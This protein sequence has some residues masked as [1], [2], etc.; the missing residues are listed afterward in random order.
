MSSLSP[1]TP[2]S[3]AAEESLL[4]ELKFP[5]FLRQLQSRLSSSAGEKSSGQVSPTHSSGMALAHSAVLRY[6]FR[7]AGQYQGVRQTAK[8]F[9]Q[10]QPGEPAGSDPWGPLTPQR[11]SC[12]FQSA[13][14]RLVS[15]RPFVPPAPSLSVQQEEIDEEHKSRLGL[16]ECNMEAA[17]GRSIHPKEKGA[18]RLLQWNLLAD[19]LS[20][21][22]FCVSPV[23]LADQWP[24]GSKIPTTD[25]PP[26]EF[27]AMLKDMLAITHEAK[28]RAAAEK[29]AG[30]TGAEL[31]ERLEAIQDEKLEE[32]ARFKRQYDTHET[33]QNLL[34]CIDWD[35]RLRRMLWLISRASPDIITMQ[36]VDHLNEIQASL[37][38]L[39]YV[40]SVE[41]GEEKAAER[42]KHH[43]LHVLTG[44]EVL[45]RRQAS[46]VAF[47]TKVGS[48]ALLQKLERAMESAGVGATGAVRQLFEAA[49]V[50]PPKSL[51]AGLRSPDFAAAGGY[52]A[53]LEY[54][55]RNGLP[56]LSADS[57]DD[58]GSV[59]FWKADRFEVRSI[60]HCV[61]GEKDGDGGGEGA[62][63]VTLRD[64]V[65]GRDISVC[66]AHL[67]SGN[68]STQEAGRLQQVR[69]PVYS[70]DG[71]SE[72]L[73]SWIG[74]PGERVI[75]AMDANSRPQFPGS[76]TVWRA[77]KSQGWNSVWDKYF[78]EAGE[79]RLERC[80]V[81]VNKMR[82]PGS[83]QAQKI[84]EHA[85]ELIDHV[86][87]RNLRCQGHGLEP[88]TFASQEEA[89]ASLLPTL[90]NPSDHYPVVADLTYA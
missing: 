90:A 33:Q 81:T 72:S 36:E 2:T 60:G 38:P 51:K 17:W 10:S 11:T 28:R 55:R 49:K 82:G 67:K 14:D 8:D 64:R 86:F 69:G 75:L 16:V 59:V 45:P 89:L 15:Q 68:S 53:L 78:S 3:A 79:A 6:I 4:E 85:Y 83:A 46:G 24:Y 20:R 48:E 18:V 32:L 29:E 65:A 63:K 62:V 57:I 26:K 12:S 61:F 21:D 25:G 77:F 47:S 66:T 54:L 22:G 23:T 88:V 52:E 13:D 5:E 39:G 44:A 30:G 73:A 40:C 87:F 42:A 74:G 27:S 31:A 9:L 80:P 71:R 50:A 19:G 76:E 41:R 84:G 56:E 58:D 7:A 35:G 70:L 1:P 37:E 34:R 43:A